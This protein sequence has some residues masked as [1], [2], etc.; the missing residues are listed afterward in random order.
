[1]FNTDLTLA[2]GHW[3]QATS[4]SNLLWDMKRVSAFLVL[5]TLCMPSAV[6]WDVCRGAYVSSTVAS[7]QI[8][9]LLR[10]LY[11]LLDRIIY[12][13]W[14]WV[15]FVSTRE[16]CW[17]P[18]HTYITAES[19]TETSNTATSSTTANSNSSVSHSYSHFALLWNERATSGLLILLIILF[20]QFDIVIIIVQLAPFQCIALLA[21]NNLS[22]RLSSAS[23]VAASTLKLWDDRLFFIV[24]MQEV[25]GR[26]AGFFPI[27]L[28]EKCS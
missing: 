14:R 3:L 12:M 16:H 13:T 6:D 26:P 19:F 21:A 9:T 27:T 8:S 17:L 7:V 22:S 25:W 5:A 10:L 18:W 23:S 24:A 11:V 2:L 4:F 15:K 1:M 20:T 28:T